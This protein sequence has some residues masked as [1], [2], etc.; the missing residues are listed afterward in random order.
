MQVFPSSVEKK[1]RIQGC[2]YSVET[3]D[4][5]A[6]IVPVLV[7]ER[8]HERVLQWTGDITRRVDT[9]VDSEEGIRTEKGAGESRGY[10]FMSCR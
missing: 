5:V 8:V 7:R 9:R 4:G 1:Q 3:W 6:G 10:V 2:A